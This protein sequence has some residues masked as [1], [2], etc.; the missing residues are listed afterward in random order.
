MCVYLI[1]CWLRCCLQIVIIVLLL[2]GYQVGNVFWT[3]PAGLQDPVGKDQCDFHSNP[4][5][6]IEQSAKISTPKQRN[7]NKPTNHVLQS[8]KRHLKNEVS[9]ICFFLLETPAEHGPHQPLLHGKF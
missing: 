9:F 8:R 4:P 2:S 3:E 6:P 7:T 5:P 1:S